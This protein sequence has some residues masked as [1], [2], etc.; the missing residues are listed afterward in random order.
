VVSP[1][2]FYPLGMLDMV[3]GQGDW[4]SSQARVMG[5]YLQG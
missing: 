1:K 3:Y 2:F 4:D 5:G